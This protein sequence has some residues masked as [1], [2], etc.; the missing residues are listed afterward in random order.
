MKHVL[1]I[2]AVLF[3]FFVM[4]EIYQYFLSW[5]LVV[6]TGG[7]G[8][9]CWLLFYLQSVREERD[10]LKEGNQYFIDTFQYIRNPISLIKTPLDV[11][12][13]GECPEFVKREVAIA[14]HSIESLEQH[15]TTLM[16]LKHSFMNFGNLDVAEHEIGSFLKKRVNPLQ[17][18][19]V[20][21]DMTLEME[22]EFEYASAWFDQG[23]VSPVIDKF[24][25]SAIDCASPEAHLVMQVL[26]N[27]E[28]WAIKI[29]DSGNG[30][31]LKYCKWYL[32]WLPAPGTVQ[33]RDWKMG[34][35]FFK[36]MLSLC[37]GKISVSERDVLLI[38]PLKCPFGRVRSRSK[39]KREYTLLEE[40]DIS[41]VTPLSKKDKP[42]VILADEDGS[43]RNYLENSLS[44]NFNIKTFSNGSE[45]LKSI[46]EERPDLVLCDISLHG[47]GGD[48]LSSELKSC[49]ETS[50]IP[51]ILLGSPLDEE[52]RKKRSCSL[53]DIFM[54]K[55]FNITDLKVEM[56]ILITNS[57][58]R[59]KSF[60][61]KMFGDEF[62]VLKTEASQQD[63]NLKFLDEVKM[64]I[65]DN[66]EK[67]DF[68]V[69]DIA[70]NMCMS[71]TT[72][73]N[74]WKSLTGEA[75]KYLISRIRMEK[76]R[77][78]LES[79]KYSVTI[80]A[81][82]VGMKNLKNFRNKYKDYF[83]KSPKEF[84]KKV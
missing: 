38:F 81:E 45:A 2:L 68:I 71:R 60:L 27:D 24:V 64:Y 31:F 57:Q 26:L 32:S 29:K 39:K 51:I 55:P 33:L 84:L 54:Y 34:G 82:M 53:A 4:I 62:L 49:R 43:F 61:Q 52:S 41:P 50:Y 72:F 48:I 76:A 17:S 83:G 3:V 1:I 79:G 67:E 58:F 77:E 22:S 28:Y 36:K 8:L 6:V 35:I 30:L 56:S 75:P 42:L 20:G 7:V 73:Y 13:E 16:G 40:T 15:L 70:S 44:D 18:Y 74:K 12:H 21:L 11:V 5:M 46:H 78:L 80:V 23:K 25:T 66:L 9:I 59:R 10:L 19:A 37:D 47:I 65:L 14:L 63:V 69:D